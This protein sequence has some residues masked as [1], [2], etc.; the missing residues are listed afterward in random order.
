M[1]EFMLSLRQMQDASESVL[2]TI[3]ASKSG[4]RHTLSRE[5]S[6]LGED[7][8]RNRPAVENLLR[9]GKRHSYVYAGSKSGLETVLPGVKI[10]VLG[11][12]TL[13][14]SET[15]GR[16]RARDAAEFWH[17]QGSTLRLM[18]DRVNK[19]GKRGILF[20]KAK[21]LPVPPPQMKLWIENL[22]HI[23]GTDL[24]GIVRTLDTVLNNTSI[25]LLFEVGGKK[26]LFPGDAQIENWSYALRIPKFRQLL[27]TVNVYKV[28]H[29]G[30]R[31]AT[32]KSLWDLFRYRS[33]KAS[34]ERLTT[35]LS[36]MSGKHGNIVNGTEVPR[37]KLV[38]ALSAE[39]SHFTTQHLRGKTLR[40][41]F[42]FRL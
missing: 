20:P 3:S 30:S 8:I 29:H 22:I 13:K 33:T 27:S 6:F 40:R 21:T 12:P 4:L 18:A 36:T 32:P 39:S 34:P 7:N 11:P 17:L 19:P 5:L 41:D 10:F 24:L 38:D 42:T 16:Q 28:G 9:M 15:I 26:F 2:R 1:R 31:N 14:Q 35:I 23:H 25:I 37:R